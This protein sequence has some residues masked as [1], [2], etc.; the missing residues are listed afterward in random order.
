MSGQCGR[1]PRLLAALA[2]PRQRE[3]YA[4]VVLG[5]TPDEPTARQRR[6]LEQLRLAGLLMTTE[7]GWET[8]EICHDLLDEQRESTPRGP[9][10]FMKDGRI[11]SWPSQAN[12]K[13]Q[14]LDWVLQRC[15]G[16]T[17]SVSETALNGRL[18]E[19][20]SDPALFRRYGVDTGLLRR[21]ADGSAY[22]RNTPPHPS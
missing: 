9:E 8:T 19:F 10:R 3:M 17:E 7:G 16:P 22:S 18:S 11:V 1:V 5:T 4:R 20:T 14:V 21:T 6:S 12:D 2:N 13:L 15:L